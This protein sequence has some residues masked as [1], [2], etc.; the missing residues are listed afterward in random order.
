[1]QIK[2][3]SDEFGIGVTKRL[4]IPWKG[5]LNYKIMGEKNTNEKM[6]I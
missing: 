1:M 3:F 6:V 5:N 2:F 4:N